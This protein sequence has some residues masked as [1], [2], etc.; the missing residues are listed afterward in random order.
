MYYTIVNFSD[1]KENPM[2]VLCYRDLPLYYPNRFLDTKGINS[3]QTRTAYA[4]ILV[5]FFNFFEDTYGITDY[6]EIKQDGA[7][8]DFMQSIVYDY[9][10]DSSGHKKFLFENDTLIA[11]STANTYMNRIQIFYLLLEKP[12]RELMQYDSDYIE[13]MLTHK[14]KKAI[15]QK[16]SYKGI[17]CV[18]DLSELKLQPNTKWKDKNKKKQSFSRYEVELLATNLKKISLRDEC[19][20]LTCV[21]TGARIT[22]ALTGLKKHF[23]TN[24]K[25]IWTFGIT[26]SK[27]QKRYVAIQPYLATKINKY[28]N[29]ERR[30]DTKNLSKYEHIFVSSK[31]NS[32]GE[33]LSYYTFRAHLREAGKAA[34]MDV[35]LVMSHMARATKATQMV[36]EGNSK[37][38]AKI[39]LGNKTV[40]NPYIDYGNPE[41]VAYTSQAL[42]YNDE[43]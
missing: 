37:E 29:T 17:W 3:G 5:R 42:Y 19:I 31:G 39:A 18:L 20:F 13:K 24:S 25:G 38:E 10:E 15:A 27:T 30:R 43:K 7:M 32:K 8:Q 41:L 2:H 14:Q 33:R 21:E 6:R 9:V 34:G 22:E 12:M 36:L 26:S 40:I 35:K 23:K 11:P 28:I 4:K 16:T 1:D